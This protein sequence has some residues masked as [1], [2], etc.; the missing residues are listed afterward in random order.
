M[1]TLEHYTKVEEDL[2]QDIKE[3]LE[4]KKVL[5]NELQELKG[6]IRVYLR[7]RPEM[8]ENPTNYVNIQN[9]NTLDVVVPP[10]VKSK[11]RMPPIRCISS[12]RARTI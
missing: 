5:N 10:Q 4:K 12:S 6:N 7:V 8:E 2:E 1:K 9:Y 3:I 11:L